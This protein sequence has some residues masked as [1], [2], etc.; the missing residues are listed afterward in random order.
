MQTLDLQRHKQNRPMVLK[1][2]HII[3]LDLVLFCLC[4]LHLK[5]RNSRNSTSRWSIK[6]SYRWN[7]SSFLCVYKTY[8][9]TILMRV[10][11]S[12]ACFSQIISIHRVQEHSCTCSW[13]CIFKKWFDMKNY[14][15]MES[16]QCCVLMINLYT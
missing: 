9:H 1:S 4:L 5:S 13:T 16:L 11:I 8:V 3:G 2:I 15:A 12:L 10:S 7:Y 6:L 14:C